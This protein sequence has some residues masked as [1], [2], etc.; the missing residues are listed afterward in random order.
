[1]WELVDGMFETECVRMCARVYMWHTV[2][3]ITQ[4][5]CCPITTQINRA[6]IFHFECVDMSLTDHNGY[7]GIHTH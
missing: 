2:T 1:M 7:M 5:S 3:H 6:D 4:S